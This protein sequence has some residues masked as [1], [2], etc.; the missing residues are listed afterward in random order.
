MIMIQNEEFVQEVWDT[1]RKITCDWTNRM[2]KLITF[3]PFAVDMLQAKEVRYTGDDLKC[4]MDIKVGKGPFGDSID[5]IVKI[6]EELT[7]VVYSKD[8]GMDFDMLVKNCYAYDSQNI[9]DKKTTRIQLSDDKG[10][11]LK[12]KLMSYFYRTRD[13]GSTGADLISFASLYAFKF[14]D[15]MD[16]YLTC[17][18]E[19]CKSGCKNVCQDPNVVVGPHDTRAAPPPPPPHEDLILVSPIQGPSSVVPGILHTLDAPPPPPPPLL[20]QEDLILAS[21]IQGPSSVVLPIPH[22]LGAP[23]PPPP[24]LP[25]EGLILASPIQDPSSVAEEL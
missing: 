16:F 6:G 2:E 19:L 25:Q 13:T 18:V 7:I 9:E 20:P 3:Q 11:L 8:G 23:P 15:K 4:W 10:C 21:P 1:A 12:P 5:G 14:P 17:E 22:I 24:L